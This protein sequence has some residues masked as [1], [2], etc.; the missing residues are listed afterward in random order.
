[1]AEIRFYNNCF[2]D[3]YKTQEY[4]FSKSLIEQI[5]NNIN[6]DE[7]KETLVECYDTET[8]KTFYAP[9]ETDDCKSI[10]IIV[11]NVSV[12][13]DYKVKETDIVSVIFLPLSQKAMSGFVGAVVGV[14]IATAYVALT[15]ASGG[16]MA[17]IMMGLTVLTGGLAGIAAGIGVY[18]LK[19][20]NSASFSGGKDSS[21]SPDVKGASN[22]SLLDNPYPFVIGKHSLTPRI[23]ADP[24]TEYTGENGKD[25]Y[26]RIVYCIGYAPLKLT[27][28]KLGDY[29]LAYNRVHSKD[30]NSSYFPEANLNTVI[31][32]V[33]RGCSDDESGDIVNK[34]KNNDIILEILQHN[35]NN[36]V[37]FGSIYPD[38]AVEQEINATPL[39]ICDSS[40]SD[41]AQVVYK[42]IT[43]P[44]R[45]R[46]NGVYFTESCPKEFTINLNIPNGIYGTYTYTNDDNLTETKYEGIPLWFAIQ[47]R[48]YHNSNAISD[49]EGSD[50]DDWKNITV[51]NGVNYG[52]TYTTDLFK[53]DANSHRGNVISSEGETVGTST[54][55]VKTEELPDFFKSTDTSTS[56][57]TYST[58]KKFITS[59]YWGNRLVLR[60][61]TASISNKN[62]QF[63]G[64][65][66]IGYIGKSNYAET[67]KKTVY[68]AI[69]IESR[70]KNIDYL[71]DIP[72]G[73]LLLDVKTFLDTKKWSSGLRD[74]IDFIPVNNLKVT[75]NNVKECSSW[76]PVLDINNSKTTT[77]T[78]KYIGVRRSYTKAIDVKRY[79]NGGCWIDKTLCNFQS[80]SG[81]QGINQIRLSST[82]KFSK[83]EC[84]QMLSSSNSIKGV[85]VRIIRVSANYIDQKNSV[86]DKESGHSY[87]DVVQL[88]SIVTKTFD[89]SKLRNENV[90]E[91][92]KIQSENDMKKFCYVAIKAKADLQENIDSQLEEF[93]CTAEAFSPI[94]ETNSTDEEENYKW[95]P[96]G[97]HKVSK[98]Y[99]YYK[100]SSR[101]QP[102]NRTSSAYEKEVTKSEYEKARC[103]GYLWVEEK[104]GSNF[105]DLMKQIVFP[106]NNVCHSVRNNYPVDYLPFNAERFNDATAASGFMLACVGP[107]NERVAFGYENINLLS[108]A[109]CYEAQQL[110]SDGSTFSDTV[111]SHTKGDFVQAKFEA[112]G[113][114]Y[115]QQQLGK[116]LQALATAG[117][118]CFTLDEK[119]KI[120]LIMDKPVDYI[121]GVISQQNCKE[122]T[123]SY[124][125]SPLPAGLRISFSDEKDGYETNGIYCWTDGN[126]IDNYKGQVEEYQIPFVTND[127]QCWMLGRYLLG[128]RSLNREVLTAKVGFEGFSLSLGDVVNV[129]SNELLIGGGSARI[130]EVL[131]TSEYVFGFVT[132][133]TY[134]YTGQTEDVDGEEK[135]TQG[136]SILQPKKSG[137]NTVVTYRL[138]TNGSAIKY[139]DTIYTLQ[140]G[141]TNI[142]L[143]DTPIGIEVNQFSTGDIVLF[144][145]IENISAKYRITKIKPSSKGSFSLT[146]IQYNE[147]L[148]SYGKELPVFKNYMTVPNPVREGMSF[149]EVPSTLSDKIQSE[150]TIVNGLEEKLNKIYETIDKAKYT[151]DVSPETQALF[152][153]DKGVVNQQWFYLTAYF[154]YQDRLLKDTEFKVYLDSGDEVGF[155]E[156]NQVKISTSYVK[157]D[158]LYLTLKAIYY[159]DDV[160]QITKE[161]KVTVV[162]IYGTDGSKLYKMLF[163][164]G[165][166]VKVD[167]T[168]KVIEPTQ[169]RVEKRVVGASGENPTDYGKV[170][171][172]VVP[173]GKEEEYQPY[174][175]VAKDEEYS[176]AT[177][178]Y[179]KNS[180][181]VLKVGDNTVLG[182]E[183]VGAL[184]FGGS[185]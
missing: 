154:Y 181:F 64:T 10:T 99:G 98:Y 173:N 25:A 3:K 106:K 90:L 185:K 72:D 44:N 2:E 36:S 97:V 127:V 86:S 148:Y 102:C 116:L 71:N 110:V 159:V 4:D 156:G 89:E 168:G 57:F 17:P 144:G 83:D 26:I 151:I 80:L 8:G 93:S 117:R 174:I 1:M 32:G 172:E 82:V 118:C 183:E 163:L 50:Y 7:Y 41:V 79:S 35:P 124:D 139:N 85:E 76:I 92:E 126:T 5:E 6:Q 170:T 153:D 91:N 179:K 21:S 88:T 29:M 56:D 155:W 52:Q 20:N 84:K 74:R 134:D 62:T 112:N 33:L 95:L 31:N 42:S 180:P 121:K 100:D 48:L 47:Y 115:Q 75:L 146:L 38:K 73:T 59:V 143:F 158:V 128:C 178:Y 49:S 138:A 119:G 161:E 11:N 120:K 18:E 177:T 113:Y 94:W 182:T 125:Y 132:D 63:F 54:V 45:F 23:V 22:Q 184:F 171:V 142:C 149:S 58:D 61:G 39:F 67:N 70:K 160:M 130:Q 176:E 157:G 37:N 167:N 111:G 27:D 34:W 162:K 166:K 129:A 16:T 15:I 13:K 30:R 152:V 43:C 136:V 131:K 141:V 87:S 135:S 108:I 24:Y 78:V 169:L 40:L 69:F 103:Q 12:D 53:I 104:I 175:Q 133:G 150:T 101:T 81:E 65:A 46:T 51:W 77:V 140:K 122:I 165:E 109:D 137:K 19:N 55:T 66:Y 123:S 28:F 147:Q 107:Q 60:S 96:Q 68:N 105:S 164:D 114:V 145:L 9:L 14:L